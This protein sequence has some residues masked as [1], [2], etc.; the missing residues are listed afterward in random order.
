MPAMVGSASAV[1]VAALGLLVGLAWLLGAGGD[2]TLPTVGRRA[3]RHI[4]HSVLERAEEEVRRA[5]RR[6][7]A[8]DWRPSLPPAA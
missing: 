3:H 4:D 5:R 8:R 6:D 2:P 7:G 1:L